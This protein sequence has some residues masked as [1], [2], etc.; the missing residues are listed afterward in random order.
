MTRTQCDQIGRFIALWVNFSKP[1]ATI[2]LPELPTFVGNFCKCVKSFY[3]Q[4][5]HF[6]ASLIDIGRLFTGHAA[7]LGRK[8]CFVRTK[9]TNGMNNFIWMILYL[10][11]IRSYIPLNK[12]WSQVNYNNRTMDTDNRVAPP[13]PFVYYFC[14]QNLQCHMCCSA[15]KTKL[16]GRGKR[17]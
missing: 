17:L 8:T 2:I 10:D 4:W 5:N 11:K 15:I 7:M 6:W 9:E 12:R 14:L 13:I 3:F 1:A 16:S